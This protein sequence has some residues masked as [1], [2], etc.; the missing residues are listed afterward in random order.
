LAR[1]VK[2]YMDRDDTFWKNEQ[3]AVRKTGRAIKKVTTYAGKGVVG[4][5]DLAGAAGLAVVTSPYWVPREIGKHLRSEDSFI[6]NGQSA[7]NQ[8]GDYLRGEKGKG[9]FISNK[10]SA[11]H[12][13]LDSIKGAYKGWRDERDFQ[14]IM[15]ET[16][17]TPSSYAPAKKAYAK[18]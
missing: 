17:Y 11:F 3:S 13:G 4:A 1:K 5:A 8:A 2:S 18:T 14:N 15:R 16:G 12:R 10:R 9:N 7:Y 6:H